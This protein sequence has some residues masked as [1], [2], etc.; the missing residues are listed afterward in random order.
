MGV[1]YTFIG[2]VNLKG[3]NVGRKTPHPRFPSEQ[4]PTQPCSD[5]GY[6]DTK[7]QGLKDRGRLASGGN[8][9]ATEFMVAAR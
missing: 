3:A 6:C 8:G 2:L 1:P 7:W 9:L 4:Q 5:A